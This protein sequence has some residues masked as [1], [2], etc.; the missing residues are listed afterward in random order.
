MASRSPT[1]SIHS[2]TA[3]SFGMKGRRSLM[4]S[5]QQLRYSLPSGDLINA[6]LQYADVCQEMG[7]GRS[8]LRLSAARRADPIIA[9]PLG[10]EAPRLA[11]VAVLYDDEEG[12]I[13]R[14]LDAASGDHLEPVPVVVAPED[15]PRFELTP[16]AL[17]Y[18][19]ASGGRA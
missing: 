19:A 1:A 7:G 18:L 3:R 2:P 10:R 6:V 11:D 14:V 15:E 12:E 9:G 17:A 16:A 4:T 5:P 13:V 8:L